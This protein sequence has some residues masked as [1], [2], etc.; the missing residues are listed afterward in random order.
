MV[1]T[2]TPD[3]FPVKLNESEFVNQLGVT[4]STE[5]TVLHWHGDSFDVPYGA[6]LLA[7]HEATKVQGYVLEK[8]MLGLL[9]HLEMNENAIE[10]MIKFAHA[11][12]E[13]TGRFIQGADRIRALK[14]QP[15]INRK[16]LF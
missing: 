8:R 14:Y 4:P 10:S 9:F 3:Q 11:D 5:E 12:L 13:R 15:E 16:F 1:I 2:N 6:A 7:S